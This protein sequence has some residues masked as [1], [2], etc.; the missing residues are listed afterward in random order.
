MECTKRTEFE[1]EQRMDDLDGMRFDW[2]DFVHNSRLI[3]SSVGWLRFSIFRV[4]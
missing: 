3:V 2:M 4:L 1:K